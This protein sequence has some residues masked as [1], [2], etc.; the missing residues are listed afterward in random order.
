MLNI[1]SCGLNCGECAAYK[2]TQANDTEKLSEL[3]S[4]WGRDRGFTAQD[5]LCDGCTSDRVYKGCTS[6]AVRNCAREQ[7]IKVCSQCGEY[8]C[9]KLEGLWK[10]Y[11]L[12]TDDMKRNLA[13]AR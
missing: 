1:A 13:K 3:A 9:G 4:K 6:C 7:G 11:N 10:G 2:A 12:N 8:P 5:M